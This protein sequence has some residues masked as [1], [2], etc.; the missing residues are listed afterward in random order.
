M[1]GQ[2]QQLR[3]LL[4]ERVGHALRAPVRHRPGMRDVGDPAGQLRVEIRHRADGTRGE[5]RVA[6]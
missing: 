2:R 1:L 4:G 3:L 6:E 5:E